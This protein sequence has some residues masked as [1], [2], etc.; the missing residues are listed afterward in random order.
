MYRIRFEPTGG[1][2]VIEIQEGWLYQ[3]CK[4]M[5]KNEEGVLTVRAFATLQLAEQYAESIG[6]PR[7]YDR[8]STRG[9]WSAIESGQL[10]YAIPKGYKLVEE[11]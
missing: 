4:V 10:N 6:L 1:F 11:Q 3:W 9:L 8:K 5:D 7:A 2:W